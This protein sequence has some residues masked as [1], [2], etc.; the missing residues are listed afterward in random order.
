[1]ISCVLPLV[2]VMWQGICGFVATITALGWTRAEPGRRVHGIRVVV[3]ILAVTTVILGWPLERKVSELRHARNDASDRLLDTL[4]I[5]APA[6]SVQQA[7]DDAAA[8]RAEFATWH[9]WSLLTLS[10]P[11]RR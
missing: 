5:A 11:W 3:L 10:I 6:A 7:R 1:M 4:R 9:L 2:Y 8:V